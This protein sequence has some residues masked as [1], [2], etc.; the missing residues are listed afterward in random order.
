MFQRLASHNEDIERL[1]EKGYAVAFDSNHLIVRDIPYLDDEGALQVGAIVAK[2]VFVDQ[3]HVQQDD[4]QVYFAGGVPHE[5]SGQPIANLAGGSANIP[6]TEHAAD[7]VVE[8]SF[9][10]K[11]II[12]GTPGSFPDF[13]AKIESY[14]A[15]ISGPAM[16]RYGASPLTFNAVEGGNKDAIFKLHDTLTSRANIADIAQRFEDEI[17]AIIGLGGTGSYV[18]DYIVKT[19]V[20]DIRAFDGDDFHVH[21]AYRA[22]GR[23]DVEEF[24]KSKADVFAGRY[25]NFRY[26]LSTNALYVDEA[27]ADSLDGVTFAFVCVDR[28]SSR[29]R[30]FDLLI[31]LQ[32]PFIDVGM[33]LKHRATGLSGSLRVTEFMP[34]HSAEV[35]QKGLAPEA[36]GPEDLYRTNVQI[37]EL[38][39]L[40]ASLAVIRF[41]QYRGFYRRDDP[42]EHHIFTLADVRI[43]AG[44]DS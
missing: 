23:V 28:G 43:F 37:A 11:P 29:A 4:H 10:N 21:N 33:G 35:R 38:N 8:R 42:S 27:S 40:N 34:E 7:V 22:P 9:S 26:G 6:L 18:L 32:I 16:D 20:R 24:G 2:L 1:V 14:V 5:L 3:D 41:K 17:V 39:A 25:D 12:H 31:E 44:D 15:I 19:R 36:D 30:I 13:F